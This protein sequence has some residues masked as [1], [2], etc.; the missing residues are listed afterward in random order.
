M[1]FIRSKNGDYS[2]LPRIPEESIRQPLTGNSVPQNAVNSVPATSEQVYAQMGQQIGYLNMWANNGYTMDS[3]HFAYEVE[4]EEGAF[5][6]FYG[7]NVVKYIERTVTKKEQNNLKGGLSHTSKIKDKP[8]EICD[9]V[10][11]KYG[12]KFMREDKPGKHYFNVYTSDDNTNDLSMV[13]KVIEKGD[14][15]SPQCSLIFKP[16]IV[17]AD[18]EKR[19]SA[20]F[21]AEIYRVSKRSTEIMLPTHP[22]WHFDEKYGF[23]F[24]DRMR[25]KELP[26]TELPPFLCKRIV[27][28][29]NNSVSSLYNN[30]KP[31]IGQCLQKKLLWSA[32]LISPLLMPLWR[33]GVA[34]RTIIAA[35]IDTTDQMSTS[36][37]ILKTGDFANFDSL[38]LYSSTAEIDKEIGGARDGVATFIGPLTAAESKYNAAK[39]NYIRDAAVGANGADKT[40]RALISLVGRFIPADLPPEFVL[41]ID[42]K[43]MATDADDN[44]L[45]NFVLEFDAAYISYIENHFDVVESWISS[46]AERYKAEPAP[47]IEK[48]KEGL[49]IALNALQS[50]MKGCFGIELFAEDEFNEVT[51]LFKESAAEIIAPNYTVR[52]Q[53]ITATIE[54]IM[55]GVFSFIDISSAHKRYSDDGSTLI[56]DR[57][58]GFLNFTMKALDKIA[59]RIPSVKDGA[60][61]ASILKACNTI[62]CTDNGARQITTPEGRFGF[63]SVYLSELGDD[64]LPIIRYIDNI[65]FFMLPE[66]VPEN[67]IPLVW[68]RG[69]CAGIVLDGK[70]LPNPH[71][72]IC[73][74]SGMGKNR[75]AYRNGECFLRLR[76]KFVF[77]NI[78]GPIT[79]DSLKDM[80]CPA[81][82]YDLFDLKTEGLPFDIFNVSDFIGKNAKV[83]YI[84]NII[85]A[86]VN[87]LTDNQLN[88]LSDYVNSMVDD[89]TQSFSLLELFEKFPNGRII[90][91][92]KKLTPLFNMM[93]AYTPKDINYKYSSCREFIDDCGRITVLSIVQSNITA[94]RCT[95]YVLLQ[96]IFEHQILDSH[97]RLV[98][99]ADEMQKYTSDSPFQQWFAEGRQYN[100]IAAG[101]TQ[102]YRSR[103]NETRNFTSNAGIELFYPPTPVSANNV[104]KALNKGFS[105]EELCSGNLGD[106]IGKG[107]FWSS[108]EKRHKSAILCGKNDDDN[109]SKLKIRP[110][111]YYGNVL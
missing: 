1:R 95:V 3:Y 105:I 110:K 89:D 70:G 23:V 83:S 15:N 51:N 21:R 80:G 5:V 22:G 2:D 41:P 52:D 98:L 60:E 26:E 75:G 102:E 9:A 11:F 82:K 19:C 106:I 71:I 25:Y 34:V 59:E 81:D 46:A 35:I 62:K 14:L 101:M 48:N 36:A 100:I 24:L 103:D 4:T 92:Q 12:E 109:F 86:A 76:S 104:F 45:R 58:K 61:L 28:T 65:E 39:V 42:C 8:I 40:A 10:F 94:L 18:Q 90:A 63:Y 111:G 33:H 56:L 54:M 78:K 7:E 68:F 47:G 88:E 97:T 43:R 27:G 77:I 31:M 69:R 20:F 29:T 37:A 67:F 57:K 13:T 53:F 85:C 74:L 93:S 49:Y 6:L 30:L 108:V 44:K 91:L 32:R 17:I 96:S 73:G 38:S 50:M 55:E 16:E 79:E 66:E 107:F 64:I 87:G 72:N 99:Y 84:L